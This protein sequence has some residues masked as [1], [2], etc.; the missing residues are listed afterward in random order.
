MSRQKEKYHLSLAG[1]LFVAAELQRR[2]VA[3]AVTYGNAKRADVIA[4]SEGSNALAIEVKS[5]ASRKWVVGGVVPAQSR[6][7]WVFVHIPEVATESPSFYVLS[8]K[9]LYDILNPLDTAFRD[10]YKQK[11]SVAYGNRK[12]IV[13]LSVQQAE[14]YKNAWLTI[15]EL[16]ARND[17]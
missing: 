13:S 1:E 5:T 8:Q 12:G 16:L 3:A 2:G 15:T 11:H 9:Q 4:I 10:S 14:P 6:A 17:A 7:P